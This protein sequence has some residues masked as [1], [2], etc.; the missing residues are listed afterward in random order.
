M[1][2]IT[3]NDFLII[4]TPCGVTLRWKHNHG[5]IKRFSAI[6][7][8][9]PRERANSLIKFLVKWYEENGYYLKGEKNERKVVGPG[10]VRIIKET[11]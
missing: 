5:V 11:R 7:R 8:P 4:K 6:G 9:T 1:K 10:P 2:K 3:K